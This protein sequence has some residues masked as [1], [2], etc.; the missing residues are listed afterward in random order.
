M[1]FN[2]MNA[3]CVVLFNMHKTGREGLVLLGEC[4]SVPDLSLS[5]I[6]KNT[7]L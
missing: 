7:L 6:F 5:R 4:S 3:Y 2:E 1:I